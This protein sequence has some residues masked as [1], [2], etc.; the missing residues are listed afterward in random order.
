MPD[1]TAPAAA[2]VAHDASQERAPKRQRTSIAAIDGSSTL[3]L[4]ISGAACERCHTR[5]VKCGGEFP[6]CAA[7]V[8][9][10]VPCLVHDPSA[11]RAYSREEYQQLYEK[12]QRLERDLGGATSLLML[13]G[14][15][16][17]I[18]VDQDG[19][20]TG[21]LRVAEGGDQSDRSITT[22][23][24]TATSSGARGKAPTENR[25]VGQEDTAFG[26]FLSRLHASRVRGSANATHE[27]HELRTPR[28]PY[29]APHPFPS[30]DTALLA[31]HDYFQHHQS[32]QPVLSPEAVWEILD[33]YTLGAHDCPAP[34]A[35][36]LFRL[37]MVIA[38]GSIRLFRDGTFEPHPFGYFT[39]ALEAW[40]PSMSSFNTIEDIEHLLLISRFG[41]FYDIG[42]SVWELGR[43]SMRTAVELGLHCSDPVA[44]ASR[45]TPLTERPRRV[46]WM[47]Y[48][49]D[50]SSS[51]TLGRPF[52]I[53]DAAITT[54]LPESGTPDN[55]NY[56][57]R[58]GLSRITSRIRGSLRPKRGTSA[59]E[60]VPGSQKTLQLASTE[61]SSTIALLRKFHFQLQEWRN[62]APSQD[63]P[64]CLVVTPQYFDLLYQEARLGLLRAAIDK[65]AISPLSLPKSLL[66][67]SLSSACSIIS[68]ADHM[69]RLN[70]WVCTRAEAHLIFVTSLVVLS[71]TQASEDLGRDTHEHFQSDIDEDPWLDF[72]DDRCFHITPERVSDTILTAGR[73]LSWLCEALPDFAVC[74]RI[75]EET[76]RSLRL[77][78]PGD[79]RHVE[80][81]HRSDLLT[82][83]YDVP[84]EDLVDSRHW[85][86][87]S[88]GITSRVST[89]M[90]APTFPAHIDFGADAMAMTE[91]A[92]YAG[93]FDLTAALT[94]EGF[95]VPPM[96]GVNSISWPLSNF[97][98]MAAID[99][100]FSGYVW[101]T[102]VPWEGSPS[103]TMD[104]T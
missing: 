49:L 74:S 51:Y 57:W 18:T 1:T 89:T 55:A 37:F 82:Q 48:M 97:E 8:K 21:L 14:N 32:A 83:A 43:L 84:R 26:F 65:L 91:A 88:H 42:C 20:Q 85:M 71:L 40:T 73:L 44:Y 4:D 68:T 103:V 104:S 2:N 94:T 81:E 9:A 12:A 33:K 63:E 76:R 15:A 69:K 24:H 70:L 79:T 46:F 52:A 67:L 72:L 78:R 87:M 11:P 13:Q 90:D 23:R 66:R 50:R 62:Q 101:D 60:A 59:Y 95:E 17:S 53:D 92:P 54:P 29:H 61:F 10:N 96:S 25:F 99:A 41:L 56:S 27:R 58:I 86:N 100:C 7:C 64:T 35:T 22:N 102:N 80:T 19:A 16:G 75:F 38:I 47:V 36:D 45:S 30:R 34:K 39:A 77:D 3:S 98:G 93:S 5:K 31:V 6:T 28:M